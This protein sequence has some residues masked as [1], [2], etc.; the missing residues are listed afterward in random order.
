ME[1]RFFKAES[2][3]NSYTPGQRKFRDAEE[4]MRRAWIVLGVV[5]LAGGAVRAQSSPPAD[6]AEQVR[7]LLERIG[8]A[9]SAA[10]SGNNFG[11]E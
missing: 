6:Q 11:S 1:A 2:S 4:R 3:G 5:L 10:A 7:M 8:G 9:T